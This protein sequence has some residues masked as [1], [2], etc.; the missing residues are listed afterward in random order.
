MAILKIETGQRY[1]VAGMVNYIGSESVHDHSVLA[2]GGV[3]ISKIDPAMDMILIKMLY[4]K[5]G[6]LLYKQIVL[7]LD[8]EESDKK[9]EEIFIK[10]SEQSAKIIADTTGCQVTYAVHGNTDNLHT[11]F[12]INSVRFSDG[13][14]YKLTG[15]LLLL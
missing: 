4:N 13:K 11:H 6:G 1:T 5:T 2:E 3:Y 8:D 15:I 10:A 12:I 9:Y 7:S 14:K